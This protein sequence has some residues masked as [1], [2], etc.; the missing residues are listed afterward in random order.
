MADPDAFRAEVEMLT[1]LGISMVWTG[2]PRGI[3]DPVGWVAQLC[4]RRLPELCDL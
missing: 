2:P 1:G 3:A 4:E